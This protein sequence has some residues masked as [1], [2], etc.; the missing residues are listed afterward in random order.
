MA[1]GGGPAEAQHGAKAREEQHLVEL[2]TQIY[3]V[4]AGED[5]VADHASV[6]VYGHVQEKTVGES[7]LGVVLLGGPGLRVVRKR[8]QFGGS[9]DINGDIILYCADRDAWNDELRDDS[10][11][12]NGGEESAGCRKRDRAEDVVEQD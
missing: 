6:G 7:K 8:D 1:A 5:L 10:E 3:A 9:Q 2:V 11:D 12:Q 4:R